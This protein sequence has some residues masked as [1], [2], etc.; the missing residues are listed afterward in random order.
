M[1]S[2]RRDRE[3]DGEIV[4]I[5]SRLRKKEVLEGFFNAALLFCLYAFDS[6]ARN[7]LKL[8]C[9]SKNTSFI[10]SRV[11]VQ[12]RNQGSVWGCDKCHTAA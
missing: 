9:Y 8:K 6:T 2:T 7:V 12:R 11:S 4:K 10:D 1:L 3:F 5:W